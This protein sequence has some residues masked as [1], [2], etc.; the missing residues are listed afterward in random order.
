M[1]CGLGEEQRTKSRKKKMENK[2]KKKEKTSSR[3]KVGWL[4]WKGILRHTTYEIFFAVL[5]PFLTE[6][7]IYAKFAGRFSGSKTKVTWFIASKF[8]TNI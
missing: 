4:G 8:G 2:R 1:F 6:T 7:A 5:K 3:P